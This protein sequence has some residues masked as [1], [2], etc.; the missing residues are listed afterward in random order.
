MVPS[1]VFVYPED[2]IK[3]A[4][5][6][7]NRA[8][9][10]VLFV[11][12]NDKKL[13]GTVADGDVRRYIL[14]GKTL[15]E[16][17]EAVCNKSPV[18]LNAKQFSMKKAEKILSGNIKLIPLLDDKRKVVDCIGRKQVFLSGG[19]I[20]P[21]RKE[22]DIPVVIMA[23][24]KSTRLE[25]FSRI[26][27]KPLMPIGNKPMIEVVID[28][29]RKYGI[30]KYYL[31]LNYKGDMIE[32]YFKSA[33][34]DYE[35]KYTWEKDFLGTA[36]SLK[37]LEAKLPDTFIVSNCDI[38]VRADFEEVVKFHDSHRAALT[39]LSS[40]RHYKIPYGVIN[41]KKGGEV[42]NIHEKPEYILTV[43]TGAYIL[44][45]KILKLIPK[46]KHFDMTDLIRV[47]I[48]KKKKIATYPVN[49]NDYVDIGQWEEYKKTIEKLQIFK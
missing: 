42:I 44:D 21:K 37:L 32:S 29:F 49:E 31:T 7:L 38:I 9:D 19:K 40:M 20:N 2:S 8:A 36:G 14:A 15:E 35:I 12:D 22:L 34:K 18:F 1:D 26:F 45:K 17:V 16:R 24:G 10:Q 43:N 28:E 11:V 13:L 33:K 6:K 46:N 30:R 39:V 41:F 4:L 27:P 5:K 23:G 25:P 47:L 48:E 3:D